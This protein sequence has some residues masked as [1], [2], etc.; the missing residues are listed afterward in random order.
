MSGVFCPE[1]DI[2]EVTR[3]VS[4]NVGEA[5]HTSIGDFVYETA[6]GPTGNY[7]YNAGMLNW[8]EWMN[9]VE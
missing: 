5:A 4:S 7:L 9:T 8:E 1:D 6:L 2:D 3:W